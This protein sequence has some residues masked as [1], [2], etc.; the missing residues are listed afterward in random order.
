[1]GEDAFAYCA[2]AEAA[3]LLLRHFE[4]QFSHERRPVL[5]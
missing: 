4:D 3:V 1:L 5:S 2:G